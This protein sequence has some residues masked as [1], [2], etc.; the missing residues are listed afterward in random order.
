MSE[1]DGSVGS[2][3][4]LVK[5][6]ET[7]DF[8]R[9]ERLA[10]ALEAGGVQVSIRP[11]Q[12]L[13]GILGA[14]GMAFAIEVPEAAQEEALRLLAAFEAAGAEPAAERGEDVPAGEPLAASLPGLDAYRSA[15]II[16]LVLSV[17]GLAVAVLTPEAA[18]PVTAFGAAIVD[19]LIWRRFSD[20]ELS[21]VSARRVRFFALGRVVLGGLVTLGGTVAGGGAAA[22]VGLV[23]LVYL[24]RQYSRP[25]GPGP[26]SEGTAPPSVGSADGPG[27]PGTWAR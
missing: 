15:S 22:W 20:P 7:D 6:T 8:V 5:L 14:P 1:P 3:E 12:E 25:L 18:P 10:E 27:G 24:A 16:G 4:R 2:S 26:A 21:V 13:S 19:F 23:V 11:T 9:A 17:L